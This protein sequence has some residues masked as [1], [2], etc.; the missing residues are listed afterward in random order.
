MKVFKDGNLDH[1]VDAQDSSKSNWMRYVNCSLSESTQN[2]MSLQYCGEIYYRACVDIP[3]DAEMVTWYGTDYAEEIG[4]LQRPMKSSGFQ[5]YHLLF[6]F[7]TV[8]HE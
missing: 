5:E 4:L 3:V 6:F 1:Y 2:V 7:I 8:A